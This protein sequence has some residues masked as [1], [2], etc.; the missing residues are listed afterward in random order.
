MKHNNLLRIGVLPLILF[1]AFAFTNLQPGKKEKEQQ[2]R[3]KDKS[4]SQPASKGK[5]ENAKAEQNNSSKGNDHKVNGN[6]NRNGND[7]KVNENR[8]DQMQQ[9]DKVAGTRNK[10]HGNSKI[11]NGKRDSE[12]NWGMENF[13]ER[14][15]PK[16]QKKVTICHNPSGGGSNGVSINVSENALQAHMNH[17]DNTGNCNIDYSDR[18]SSNYVKSR[19]NVYNRYEQTWETMS[20]SE[21]LLNLAVSKLLGLRTNLDNS[22]STM[23]SSEIQRREA[24][25]L[26]LQNN[27]N[28]LDTQLGATRQRLDSDVNIL[29]TL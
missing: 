17:G 3:E 19:E 12:I 2:E 29:I 24:L 27:V 26:D 20:Y 28:S 16:N 25:I 1:T 13:A 6:D 21:A 5:N 9:G 8:K 11:M 4:K 7:H 14:K 22:R 18:W 10:S 23:N 15:H